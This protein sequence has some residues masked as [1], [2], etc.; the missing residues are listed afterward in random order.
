MEARA[1]A[2]LGM[3]ITDWAKQYVSGDNKPLSV[4]VAP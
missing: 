1:Q 3:S 4:E 2:E